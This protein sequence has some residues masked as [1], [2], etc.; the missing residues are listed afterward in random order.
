M[1]IKHRFSTEIDKG[2]AKRKNITAEGHTYKASYSYRQITK[3]SVLT[4]S[5]DPVNV[6]DPQEGLIGT[7]HNHMKCTENRMLAVGG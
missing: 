7:K 1:T 3:F 4:L 5:V 2:L 6:L